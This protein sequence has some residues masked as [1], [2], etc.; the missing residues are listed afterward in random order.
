MSEDTENLQEDLEGR[1]QVVDSEIERY[2][3]FNDVRAEG[4]SIRVGG[5][6][7]KLYV[8]EENDVPEIEEVRNDLREKFNQ[9][10]QSIK[11]YLNE[12]VS[13]MY[14]T[15]EGHKQAVEEERKKFE[16]ARIDAETDRMPQISYNLATEGLSV[17]KGQQSGS[18]LWL[19][20]DFYWPKYIDGELIDVEFS[21]SL[22]T[23]IVIEIVTKDYNVMSCRVCKFFNLGKFNHYHAMGSGSDCWGSWSPNSYTWNTPEDVLNIGKRAS[24]IITDVN[25]GSPGQENPQ[26]LPSMQELKNN[27]KD[28]REE[29][30][31]LE[32]LTRS[33][34]R[35]GEMSSNVGSTEAGP[36]P[37]DT[38]SDTTW[39]VD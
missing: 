24:Q 16:R 1:R 13:G 32:S 6:K 7:M 9:K 25:T 36:R 8:D 21:K 31:K 5:R 19:Y 10:L 29:R 35:S 34:R 4:I 23:P 27:V 33:M 20:R 14:T 12:E 39:T 38:D 2:M 17:T 26:G 30:E 3:N 22:I 18:L 37:R 15:F 11:D 28:D